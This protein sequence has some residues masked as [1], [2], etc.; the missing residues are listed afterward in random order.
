[1]ELISKTTLETLGPKNMTLSGCITLPAVHQSLERR[2][3]K[4]LLKTT[5]TAMGHGTF[6]HWG[7]HSAKATL[8]VNTRG[9]TGMALLNQNFYI[10]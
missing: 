10:L 5:L 7:T 9:P 3:F 1:M 6:K 8:L 2:N 4:V